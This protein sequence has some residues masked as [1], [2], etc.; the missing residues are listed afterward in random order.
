[1]QNSSIF[2]RLQL[3]SLEKSWTKYWSAQKVPI[4]LIKWGKTFSRVCLHS[5]IKIHCNTK[6]IFCEGIV[7][8]LDN[9]WEILLKL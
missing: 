5:W 7:R 1:M 4:E 2:Y 3:P 8:V 9:E 6:L